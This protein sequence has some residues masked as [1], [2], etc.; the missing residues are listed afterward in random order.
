MRQLTITA[1]DNGWLAT[2]DDEDEPDL[3]IEMR[4]GDPAAGNERISGVTQR[5]LAELLECVADWAGYTRDNYG[6]ENLQL[7]FEGNGKCMW[8]KSDDDE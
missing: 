7:S 2:C 1:A 6:S 3:V 4:D 5:G 8:L